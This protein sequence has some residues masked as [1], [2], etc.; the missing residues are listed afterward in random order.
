M[1][2]AIFGDT[3]EQ[4]GNN[5]AAKIYLV[6]IQMADFEIKDARIAGSNDRKRTSSISQ[7][8]FVLFSTPFQLSHLA[9]R[10]G[11]H[12]VGVRRMVSPSDGGAFWRTGALKK[13]KGSCTLFLTC[14][15]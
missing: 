13:P 1:Q 9:D 10:F 4:L 5:T 12:C 15:S 6:N 8:L 3:E 7:V 2:T 14:N 11:V